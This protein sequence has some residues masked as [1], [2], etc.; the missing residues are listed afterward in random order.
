MNRSL[1]FALL[2]LWS[3]I[4]AVLSAGELTPAEKAFFDRH[5]S[6]L[7]RFEMETMDDLAI[8]Q[9]FSTPFYKL[10]VLIL[11]EG[12]DQNTK[13]IV[14]R[15][16]DKLVSVTRPGT[17][18]DLPEFQKL[19]NPAF[20]LRTNADAKMLQQALDVLFPLFMQSDKKARS[21]RRAGD[22]WIF[23]RAEFD[24]SKSGYIFTT[25]ANGTIKSVKYQLRLP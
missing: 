14:T 20:K 16:G 8:E 10:E 24:E 21:F 13:L 19:L 1:A 25:D 22:T 5:V 4:P 23:A 15:V 3:A 18:G 12:G 17:D 9:V 11:L 2:T 7:V 6:D